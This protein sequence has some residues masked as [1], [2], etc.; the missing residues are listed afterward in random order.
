M[1]KKVGFIK[2][3]NNINSEKPTNEK[4]EKREKQEKQEKQEKLIELSNKHIYICGDLDTQKVDSIINQIMSEG[5]ENKPKILYLFINSSGGY[6]KDY[7]RLQDIIDIVPYPVIKIGIGNISDIG[8]LLLLNGNTDYKFITTNANLTFNKIQT[9]NDLGFDRHSEYSQ[10]YVN[11]II[12]SKTKISLKELNKLIDNKIVINAK[13]CV[14]YGIVSRIITNLANF[15]IK[16][17]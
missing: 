11:D 2:T 9:K 7:I 5:I 13:R 8:S 1:T 16:A 10:E 14:K 3:D 12:T 6:I 17:K 4:Q 15:Q